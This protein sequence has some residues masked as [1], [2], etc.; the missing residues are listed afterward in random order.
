VSIYKC[1]RFQRSRRDTSHLEDSNMGH[2]KA[3]TLIEL[4][5]VIA[6]IAILIGL[7]LPAVQ[8]VREAAF[9][10]QCQNNLKQIGL[11]MH[12][13]HDVHEC[14]P[15][16]CY[17]PW[18][19][20]GNGACQDL[21]EP[22]GPNWAV[23]ILPY[24]EQENLYNL[25]RTDKYPGVSLSLIGRGTDPNAL[26]L[27][28][29]DPTTGME[30]P[31]SIDRTWRRMVGSVIVKTYVCPSD[32]NTVTPY[33]DAQ[34]TPQTGLPNGVGTTG[35]NDNCP[36][37]NGTNSPLG[38]ARGNY[39]VAC[40]FTDDDHTS[41]GAECLKNNPFDGKGSD[42]IVP[43]F[44][45]ANPGPPVSKG[46][47]FYNATKPTNGTRITVISDGTSNTIM[48]N[49]VRAGL[50]PLDIRGTWA[51]GEP[52][53]SMTNAGRSYNPTPNNNLES[54]AANGTGYGDEMQSCYKFF[55]PGMGTVQKM[56]CFPVVYADPGDFPD[57]QNSAMARSQHVG[58][59]NA[60]FCDG[61]VRFISNAVDQFTW[62]TLQ[63]KDDGFNI[64]IPEN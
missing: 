17:V 37:P 27:G 28:Q 45:P 3:F 26:G 8:K 54:T 21:T 57:L 41:D 20:D 12:N 49:E 4:L 16:G 62:C 24:I 32:S 22:K 9:R 14:L 56:G 48:V 33:Y 23:Y 1:V 2:R 44:T 58:G 29:F 25:A 59:V 55:Q 64:L 19:Q 50:S 35:S 31:G 6:I 7:L 11:A 34:L 13:Y 51:I 53:A 42:G 5:V 47:V 43:G 18:A 46:P 40:G 15:V 61:S 60:C 52:G 63:S 36:P 10:T 30:M 38:W 39:A